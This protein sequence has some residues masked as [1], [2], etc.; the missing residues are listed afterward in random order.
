VNRDSQGEAALEEGIDLVVLGRVIQRY[1]LVILACTLLGVAA[2]VAF[3]LLATPMYRAEVT[4]TEVHDSNLGNSNA[5]AGQLSGLASLAGVTLGAA[6][7]QNRDA[8][9][10]LKSRRLAEQFIQRYGLIDV[11]SQKGAEHRRRPTERSHHRIG[12]LE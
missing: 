12:L 11:F 2:A 9:A 4:I 7:G 10:L 8:Q 1:K 3:V 6:A 5:I